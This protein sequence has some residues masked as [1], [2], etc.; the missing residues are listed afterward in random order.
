MIFLNTDDKQIL[1]GVIVGILLV[2][3]IW[4]EILREK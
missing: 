2:A 4:F 3:Y 1:C